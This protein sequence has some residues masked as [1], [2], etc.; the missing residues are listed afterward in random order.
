MTELTTIEPAERGIT[1]APISPA[2][3]QAYI[4]YAMSVITD[5]ALPD[6]RDGLKPVHRRILWAMQEAGNTAS[7]GYRKAARTVGDVI[8]KYH[9]H[10]DVSVYDAAVLMAQDFSMAIPL[11]DGQGNFGSID[12]DKPAAMRYTEMR[13]AKIAAE[14]FADIQKETVLWVPNYDGTEKEPAVVPMP[15]PNLLVNGGE[16]IAVG[17]ASKIP[18]HNLREVCAATQLLIDRPD[19]SVAEL[20]QIM[21]GPDF[22]TCAL[23]HGMDGFAQAMAEGSGQ[24]KIRARWHP[25][26]RSRGASAIVIDELPYK[27]NKAALVDAI[28]DLVRNKKIEGIT[29]IRDESNKEGIRVWI[30]LK[31]DVSPEVLFS[32]LAVKTNLEVSVYYNVVLLDEGRPRKVGLRE[33][34]L[35]WID[36][37]REVVLART[38]YARKQ[39]YARQHILNA[40]IAALSN[41]DEVIS[42]I[43]A[44]AGPAEARMGLMELLAV[45][46]EQAQAILDLRLQKL[47]GLEIDGI[48]AEHAQLTTH[49]AELTAIIES[50]ARIDAI[51]KE[52]LT[53]IAARFGSDRRTEIAY[54][55]SAITREDLIEREQVLIT[56]TKSGYVKRLPAAA[57]RSQNR[58][59]RGKLAV[60]V[61]EGDTLTF[62]QEVYSHDKLMV[63]TESGQ[64]YSIKA[65]QVPE[66]ALTARG[67]HIKNVIEGLEGEIKAVLPV[68]EDESGVSLLTVTKG[69]QIKRTEIQEY[70]GAAH[71]GGVRGVGLADG[72]ELVCAFAVRDDEQIF[73]VA[74]D[75][76]CI[77]FKVTDARTMGRP[78]AG[79]RGIRLRSNATVIGAA[80]AG[81]EALRQGQLLCVSEA[82]M[83][84]R[85]ELA[86]FALQARGG[87][88][89]TAY[90]LTRKTG[91]LVSAMAVDA[92]SDLVL[93]ASNG[94]SNRVA[95]ETIRQTGR[96][97]SGVTLMSLDAGARIVDASRSVRLEDEA[98]PGGEA[99]IENGAGN[100]LLSGSA[101]EVAKRMLD[102]LPKSDSTTEAE[103]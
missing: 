79:V 29:D 52:E 17:M 21:T 37:R 90:K 2:M 46:E 31:K 4:D 18:P 1:E 77:R 50:P 68:P 10:G 16:G 28:A 81:G 100:P 11:I 7:R 55:L 78:A 59:T 43:R 15:Y 30:A 96:S 97:A 6:V 9:P 12:G 14:I 88:G 103:S 60:A 74:S 51:I 92:S 98:A 87:M 45:D 61:D 56:M 102:F 63:L 42:L 13:L 64:A 32:E 66:G 80:V 73:I 19:A 53:D 40:F 41:L 33:I 38:I 65:Y 58:G 54:G 49:I 75:G 76:Q 47:T 83:G 35:R 86:E 72:D 8:G 57:L 93:L 67:R 34:M 24:V 99:K 26:E 44:A 25:E 85:T 23:V 71:K 101:E 94:V 82:G 48:R 91:A 62:L 95:V 27:V 20:L 89:V 5:R 69:G 39:A 22:P 3:R 36:F 70:A 84:K